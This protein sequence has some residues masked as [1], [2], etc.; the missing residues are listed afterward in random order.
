MSTSKA[1]INEEMKKRKTLFLN[2]RAWGNNEQLRIE[3]RE[4]IPLWPRKD[5]F[6]WTADWESLPAAIRQDIEFSLISDN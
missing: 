4:N 2:L 3:G 6:S 1:S 5:D